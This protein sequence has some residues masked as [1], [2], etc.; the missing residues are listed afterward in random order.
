M[1]I[2]RIKRE[3]ETENSPYPVSEI[4]YEEL[5]KGLRIDEYALEDSWREQPELFHR[6]S[7]KLALLISQRDDAKHDLALV[8]AEVDYELR[9]AARENEIKITEKEV[10]AKKLQDKG[11]EEAY[12]N[13]SFLN[14]RVAEFGA[15][16]DS[17]K[18]RSS[19]LIRLTDLYLNEHYNEREPKYAGGRELMDRKDKEAREDLRRKRLERERG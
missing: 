8:E 3:R 1:S 19:A 7:K 18:Q 15:L 6:V 16:A 5:E 2:K 11:V 14:L 4:S 9:T 13:L 10:E 17:F 12:K